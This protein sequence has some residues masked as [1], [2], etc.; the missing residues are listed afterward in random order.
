MP[1]KNNGR[2]PSDRPLSQ[3][4]AQRRYDE[5]VDRGNNAV[6]EVVADREFALAD[7]LAEK[8]GVGR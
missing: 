8:Y 2:V 6:H 7:R 1:G 3:Q 5:A 4:Q